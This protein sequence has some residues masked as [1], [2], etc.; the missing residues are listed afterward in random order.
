[1]LTRGNMVHIIASFI[2]GFE[3]KV[4]TLIHTSFPDLTFSYVY[5]CE[6]I[7]KKC[8]QFQAD[9][10]LKICLLQLNLLKRPIL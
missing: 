10:C 8:Q 6:K 2:Y 1:M 9:D 4:V 7:Q 5:I 3:L